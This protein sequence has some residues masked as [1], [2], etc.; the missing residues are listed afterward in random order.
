MH[1]RFYLANRL[2]QLRSEV[3]CIADGFLF[4]PTGQEHRS[5]GNLGG[6]RVVV[7]GP[8]VVV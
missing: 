1:V 6:Q 2:L 3:R 5:W 8:R 4:A 7:Q